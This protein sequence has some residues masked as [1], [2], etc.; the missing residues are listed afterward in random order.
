MD[1]LFSVYNGYRD[2][3]PAKVARELL[4]YGDGWHMKNGHMVDVRAKSVGHGV[5]EVWFEPREVNP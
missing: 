5:S 3:V 2:R 4:L 1:H